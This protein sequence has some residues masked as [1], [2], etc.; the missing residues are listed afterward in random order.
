VDNARVA[1]WPLAH[2]RVAED[3][4]NALTTKLR[5][6]LEQLLEGR[7]L[8]PAETDAVKARPES[9]ELVKC[10]GE[11]RC[12]SA[13]GQMLTAGQVITGVARMEGDS[14]ALE[15][16][17]VDVQAQREVG[18]VNGIL[19]RS[20]RDVGPV[21]KELAARLAAPEK[22]QGTLVINGLAPG[23][24]ITI[25][26]AK[27]SVAPDAISLRV[28][29][30]V[31][32]HAVEIKRGGPLLTEVVD[33]RFEEI[34]VMMAPAP[35]AEPVGQGFVDMTGKP[36]QPGIG[37]NVTVS[38]DT[39]ASD[40]TVRLPLWIGPVVMGLALPPLVVGSVFLFD[41]MFIGPLA[42]ANPSQCQPWTSSSG[43]NVGLNPRANP[44]NACGSFWRYS[45]RKEGGA[46][47][48]VLALD[49]AAVV[50]SGLLSVGM[51]AVG[52]LLIGVA[53]APALED[54]DA[55]AAGKPAA[56]RMTAIEKPPEE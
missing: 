39:R 48:P 56:K 6:Q 9:K 24:D 21:L 35:G 15:L 38:E 23:L 26:G 16:R 45:A 31:G 17:L 36:V 42:L 51:L 25:D 49:V 13:L 41:L 52:G 50:L 27:Q 19:P 47:V 10:I 4:A 12:L 20:E 22:H 44:G 2:E 29:L 46:L 3:D 18:R 11:V 28:S 7:L 34:M 30:Q 5:V 14:R 37:P 1:L 8:T 54:K 40:R 32:K 53:L 43:G 33:I 55:E